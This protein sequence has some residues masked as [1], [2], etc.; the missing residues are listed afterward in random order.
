MNQ[1][2]T[3]PQPD[4][5]IHVLVVEDDLIVRTGLHGMLGRH[6]SEVR[7]A[8]SGDEGLACWREWRPD[9]VLTDIEMPGL[10]GLAM[11]QA[12]KAE[13]P[14]AQIIVISASA[15]TGNLRRAMEAG[16]ER[17]VVK[18]VDSALLLDA[19][20]K[21]SRDRRHRQELRLN[22]QVTELARELQ[23]RLWEKEETEKALRLSEMRLH[24]AQ[25]VAR[26][27]NWDWDVT[28]DAVTWSVGMY[29]LLGVDPVTFI[30][31]HG[32]FL[33]CVHPDD[34]DMLDHKLQQAFSGQA[35][36]PTDHRV[37]LPD[38]TVKYVTTQVEVQR[39]EHGHTLIMFGTLLDITARKRIEDALHREKAEQAGLIAKLEEA[40]N[41]LLQ[42]EKMASIGQLA[43]GVAHEINNPIG[44]VGSNLGSLRSYV[45]RLLDVL[46]AYEAAKPLLPADSQERERIEASEREA[47]LAYLKEDVLALI[48]ESLDGIGR[49]R[50]IVQDLKDFSHVDSGEWQHADLHHGL[51]S[52]LN[53]VN[54]EIK[55]KAEVIKEYGRLPLVECLASQIN[56]VFMNLLV[57]AAHAI[58]ERGT[59][60]IRTGADDARVWVEIAD[61]GSGIPPENLKRIFDPF[62]TTKPI[63]KGTGLGLSLV[64]GIVKKHDGRIEV[65]SEPGQGTTFRI[66]LP[67]KR[68]DMVA[69]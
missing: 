33:A 49:V 4:P 57:N 28:R 26:L 46:A 18:P 52:T 67:I 35:V 39:D 21:C 54:N 41:Q 37:V 38:G 14:D 60:A 44:F 48:A 40:H 45:E 25:Q 17:Y 11:S 62:F 16:I 27:G 53:V 31:T 68:A 63:G 30:P 19:I 56:Q 7:L 66:T 47:E 20:R 43:A 61:T 32:S 8:A 6:V 64:Y 50:R 3:P 69:S 42:S 65:E 9:V 5:D 15:D 24:K 13:D 10:D 51:D 23:Q 2:A 12:I 58:E 36:G 34:L 22:R 1:A 59:I 55:Y 29:E